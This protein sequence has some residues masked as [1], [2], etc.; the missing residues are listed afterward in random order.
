M[1]AV[2]TRASQDT[3]RLN[4]GYWMLDTG[5]NRSNR[6]T[7]LTTLAALPRTEFGATA[8]GESGEANLYTSIRNISRCG[9]GRL[10][11]RPFVLI[12]AYAGI[13]KSLNGSGV[14][15]R[16]FGLK[17]R[18]VEHA[19]SLSN[20]ALCIHGT[21]RPIWCRGKRKGKNVRADF[22]YY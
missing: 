10:R 8:F 14:T 1:L 6:S 4:R 21:G 11:I 12:P 18:A 7:I 22:D 16:I 13:S 20:R 3:P 15:E 2:T 5:R 17:I 19:A 9:G